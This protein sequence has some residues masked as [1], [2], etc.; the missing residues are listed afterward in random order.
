LQNARFY[1]ARFWNL[2][3]RVLDFRLHDLI[4]P[5]DAEIKLFVVQ[6]RTVEIIFFVGPSDCS[7]HQSCPG[8]GFSKLRL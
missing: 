8:A 7:Y 1:A 2:A 5:A 6:S 4:K 3:A